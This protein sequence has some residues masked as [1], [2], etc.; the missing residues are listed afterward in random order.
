MASRAFL[1]RL[2]AASRSLRTAP[3][4]FL[5][6]S[7]GSSTRRLAEVQPVVPVKKPVGAFR[8]GLFG[9][10]LGSTLAG[11]SVYYYILEEYKVSNE[12]LTEDIYALQAAVQRIHSSAHGC[13]PRYCLPFLDTAVKNDHDATDREL[14]LHNPRA[15]QPG[16]AYVP[17]ASSAAS[18]LPSRSLAAGDNDSRKRKRAAVVRLVDSQNTG[19]GSLVRSDGTVVQQQA[20]AVAGSR[21]G[22]AQQV[23][24]KQQKA[25]EARLKDLGRENY[26]DSAG[27]VAIPKVEGA[28]ASLGGSAA[29]GSAAGG[30]ATAAAAANKKA[31]NVKRILGYNRN[32]GHYLADEEAALA[33]G[34]GGF[35]G[36]WGS[37]LSTNANSNAHT[38]Y[39]AAVAEARKKKKKAPPPPAAAAAATTPVKKEKDLGDVA[40]TG[41]DSAQPASQTPAKRPTV[42]P[43]SP[44]TDPLLK[45]RDLPPKPSARVIA[46]L[47]AEPPLSY[48]AA[49]AT[50]LPADQQRPRRWFCGVC[51]YF[52]R[53]KCRRCG[54]RQCGLKE[55]WGLHEQ[56]GCVPY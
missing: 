22:A 1:P 34:G 29:G 36:T 52:G 49:R 5:T 46:A 15:A 54:E 27:T 40:M 35:Q 30:S 11:A 31:T 50:P 16:W 38:Q 14:P 41:T 26:K 48:A 47:L 24:G 32:F 28:F 39:A 37:G 13:P 25:I 56:G 51:G 2:T 23:T 18:N 42:P 43:D 53:V 9:F 19:G 8:G 21:F 45:T 3:S 7:F 4:P 12:L 10:L 17:D 44:T 33:A 6:R 55:C 20:G